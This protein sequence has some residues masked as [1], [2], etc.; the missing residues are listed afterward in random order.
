VDTKENY[1]DMFTKS[2]PGTDME[3]L[4]EMLKGNKGLHQE[5]TPSKAE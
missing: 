2:V 3:H 4:G 5:P 1:S